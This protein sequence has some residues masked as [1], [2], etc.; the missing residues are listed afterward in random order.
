LI[1]IGFSCPVGDVPFGNVTKH[2]PQ[3][4]LCLSK[5]MLL[6]KAKGIGVGTPIS[7]KECFE[8]ANN[9][10]KQLFVDSTWTV[11][12][13]VGNIPHHSLKIPFK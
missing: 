2:I 11:A 12:V 9:V 1:P 5:Q 10:P 13:V 8:H 7:N 6:C 3:V 4:F